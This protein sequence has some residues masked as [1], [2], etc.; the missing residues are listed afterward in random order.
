MQGQAPKLPQGSL[1]AA[2][3]ERK[4]QSIRE[5]YLRVRI[6]DQGQMHTHPNQS[7]GVLSSTSWSNALA[8]VPVD[9]CIEVNQ[10]VRVIRYDQLF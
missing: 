10:P 2:S 8:I 1:I 4:K 7:S 5:E 6:D 9:T 3:F